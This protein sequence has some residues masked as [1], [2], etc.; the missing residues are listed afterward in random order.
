MESYSDILSCK[1]NQAGRYPRLIISIS[2][3][4]RRS[5]T[6]RTSSVSGLR[7]GGQYPEK[8]S[9]IVIVG[10]VGKGLGTG[11]TSYT[12]L[13]KGSLRLTESRREEIYYVS[14]GGHSTSTRSAM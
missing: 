2:N 8:N 13:I 7:P 14:C 10:S 9:S 11:N 1:E 3:K 6:F 5:P 12:M 4:Q